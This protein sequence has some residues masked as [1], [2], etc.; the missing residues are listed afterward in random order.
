MLQWYVDVC[1]RPCC[2]VRDRDTKIFR[3]S[4]EDRRIIVRIVTI[5]ANDQGES[6]YNAGSPEA[7]SDIST[8]FVDRMIILLRT[9]VHGR[10]SFDKPFES[11][12]PLCVVVLSSW[13]L[14]I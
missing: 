1:S 11:V 8:K 2:W 3:D 6:E 14:G 5:V 10:M 7:L 13:E 4:D 9:R 12:D